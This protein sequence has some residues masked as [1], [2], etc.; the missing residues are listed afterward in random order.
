VL[1]LSGS[2]PWIAANR[3]GKDHTKTGYPMEAAKPAPAP[4]AKTAA[5]NPPRK[6]YGARL[7]TRLDTSSTT[8]SN[9][10]RKP[11][12]AY[13]RFRIRGI[14]C[15]MSAAYSGIFAIRCRA[16]TVLGLHAFSFAARKAA[17]I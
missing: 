5:K 2:A 13:R 1:P 16:L 6:T 15:T 9:A 3:L 12:P 10:K 7:D 17:G 14:R 8:G 4:A 11:R